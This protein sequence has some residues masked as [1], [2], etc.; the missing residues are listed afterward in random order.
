MSR[1]MV[2]GALIL[3]LLLG[4]TPLFASGSQEAAE[5]EMPTIDVWH[6]F[7][8][9]VRIQ[10]MEKIAAD[11]TEQRGVNV[12][13]RVVPWA[14]VQEGWT[15]AQ[16]AG[17]LPD[18]MVGT[19][20]DAMAVWLAGASD[21]MND[22]F[23][24][25]GGNDFF[26]PGVVDQF[27]RYG[28][29]I[30][31]LPF[32]AHTRLFIYRADIFDEAGV[33]PPKTWDEL[34]QVTR[35]V[36]DPPQTYGAVQF[37]GTGDR[38]ATIY[39]YTLLRANEASFFGPD[40]SLQ[41]QTPEF[42]ETVEFMVDWYEAGA[43]EGELGLDLHENM[44]SMYSTGRSAIV[45]DTAFL[46]NTLQSKNPELFDQGGFGAFG[47]P[48]N[49]GKDRAFFADAPSLIN[50]KG[51]DDELAAEF[52]KFMYEPERYISFLHT[53]P[54]GQYPVTQSAADPNS[55]F[56]G[57]PVIGQVQHAV[58]LTLEGIANGTPVG[59]TYGL[60]PNASVVMSGV[61][62]RMMQNIVGEGMAVD[63]AIDIAEEELL[64]AIEALE[65]N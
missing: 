54:A 50:T 17:T 46:A 65:A 20:N 42:R 58:E 45:I 36:N 63:R 39:L 51:G 44:Y 3:F 24:E 52:I 33:A 34:L 1:R 30:V 32:Y 29:D 25:M 40:G 27:S 26:T 37:W 2:I 55:S 8:Q 31:S 28:D 21:P 6:T 62:E 13:L 60:N 23:E 14:K 12:E 59:M 57:H 47:T 22:I 16:A 43:P 49:R 11:F 18:V 38:G 4:A 7:T 56:W 41:I 9:D 15:T 10:E 48:V 53:I 61:F 35:A 64:D 5:E 19:P